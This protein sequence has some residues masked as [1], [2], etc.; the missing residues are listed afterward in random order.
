MLRAS[1]EAL[2]QQSEAEGDLRPLVMAV[3]V[4][5]S[6]DDSDLA[7]MGFKG[8]HMDTVNR[9]AG[10]ALD[11]DDHPHVIYHDY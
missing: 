4:L 8:G 7:A 5:T 10:L 11:A 6:L 1:L 9:L 3:T 2:K